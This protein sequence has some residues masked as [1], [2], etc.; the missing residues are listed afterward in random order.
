MAA[1]L[2]KA[3]AVQLQ[4]DDLAEGRDQV[5]GKVHL[6]RYRLG[7]V[8][9]EQIAGRFVGEIYGPLLLAGGTYC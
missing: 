2:A 6:R 1:V 9:V 4:Q 8:E 3:D 5:L 7:V